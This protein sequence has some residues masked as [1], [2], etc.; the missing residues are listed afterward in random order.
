MNGWPTPALGLVLGMRHVMD[1][2]HAVAVDALAAWT[3][4]TWSGAWLDAV[5]G[6]GH[7]LTLTGALSLVFGAWLMLQVGLVEGLFLP[8]AH[9]TPR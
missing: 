5:W 2:D 4:R 3:R 1:P 7:T 6:L 8:Q 9:W